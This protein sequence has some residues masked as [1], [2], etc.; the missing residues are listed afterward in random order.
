MF[1]E[2]VLGEILSAKLSSIKLRYLILEFALGAGD[3]D[4][5]IQLRTF[6]GLY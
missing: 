3:T 4:V 6:V 2:I 1:A 5:V